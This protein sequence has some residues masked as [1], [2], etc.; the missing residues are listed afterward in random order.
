[1]RIRAGDADAF[2]LLMEGYR[3][4]IFQIAYSVV[5]NRADAEDIVQE[6]F[7]QI[8]RALP[9]YEMKGLKAWISRIT[10]N[11]A[12]DYKRKKARRPELVSQ[13]AT[14][15][16]ALRADHESVDSAY[17]YEQNSRDALAEV[18]DIERKEQ[19]AAELDRIPPLHREMVQA[20]YLEDKSYDQIA[21]E[22]HITPK[23]VE[24]R[25]YRARQWLRNHWK[26]EDWR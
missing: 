22:Q 4:H 1:M 3:Q 6:A 23:T 24:S 11:K 8:H 16:G 10:I 20:F 17:P 12:I 15:D 19:L 21:S 26:E 9:Q 14:H 2:R 5:R 7:I 13:L 25:L 18:L